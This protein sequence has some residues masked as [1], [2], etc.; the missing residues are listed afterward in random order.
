M[1]EANAFVDCILCGE[2][3]AVTGHDGKMAL[4]LV[5]AGLKS[6]LEKR[7]VQISEMEE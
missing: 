7:P 1:A 2:E 5:N 4:L 6:I 3:P